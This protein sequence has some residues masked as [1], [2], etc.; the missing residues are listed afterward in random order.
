MPRI[1]KR[2]KKLTR[3]KKIK[4]GG[5]DEEQVLD[6]D[7]KII[8]QIKEDLG[9]KTYKRLLAEGDYQKLQEIG[10][11]IQSQYD[12]TKWNVSKKKTRNIGL[13][14][15]LTCPNCSKKS[16]HYST[17]GDFSLGFKGQPTAYYFCDNIVCRSL[18]GVGDAT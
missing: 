8:N 7:D 2:K 18:I 3:K 5:G 6:F 11:F 16:I 13:A 4:R 14:K 10:N 15:N 1:N 9:R 12:Y 17:T